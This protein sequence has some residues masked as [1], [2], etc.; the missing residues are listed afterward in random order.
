MSHGVSLLRRFGLH[1]LS[2][3]T[4]STSVVPTPPPN[5]GGPTVSVDEKSVEQPLT[6]LHAGS[7]SLSKALQLLLVSL[8][9][10]HMSWVLAHSCPKNATVTRFRCGGRAYSL[11]FGTLNGILATVVLLRIGR[12][13]SESKSRSLVSSVME[14]LGFADASL[15]VTSIVTSHGRC[16][17]WR[18]WTI[19]SLLETQS[20]RKSSRP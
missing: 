10:E 13:K 16:T 20:L 19:S 7:L 18:M 4:L 2:K 11:G 9:T 8:W 5:I 12:S 3:A 17:F 14:R 15:T 1:K 6:M